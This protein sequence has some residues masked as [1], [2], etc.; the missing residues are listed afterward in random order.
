M[1]TFTNPA[2]FAG[3]TIPGLRPRTNVGSRGIPIAP[4]YLEL[5]IQGALRIDRDGRQ[6]LSRSVERDAAL[7]S[8]GASSGMRHET[9]TYITTYEIPPL[10]GSPLTTM[11]VPDFITKGDAGGDA[12][13]FSRRLPVVHDYINGARADLV[14]AGP[15][16]RPDNPIHILEADSDGWTA[17]I[18]GKCRTMQWAETD[19][20]TRLLLVTP[21]GSTPILWL[22]TYK[23]TPLSYDQIGSITPDARNWTRANI[24][25][26]FPA[27]FSTHD[28]RHTYAVY[29]TI[30]IFK[31][32][33]AP[34]IHPDAV[35]AYLPARIADAVEIAK[36]SRGHASI[37]STKLYIQHAHK[38]LDIPVGEILGER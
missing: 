9:L 17:D 32:A 21:E 26:L 27:R 34:Y 29:L 31:Q 33:L 20:P 10:S 8:L 23:P 38:F 7:I 3:T 30:C 15:P 16:Y 11:R 22:N 35:D 2:G 18:N 14:T 13:V 1:V 5:L 6:S 12:F 19:G 25:D 4:G 28:L 37:S 36:L 24:L